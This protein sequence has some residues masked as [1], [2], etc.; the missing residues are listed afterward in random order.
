[1]RDGDS[2]PLPA[3]AGGR[4]EVD[5]HDVIMDEAL[6]FIR[7]NRDRPFFAY[8]GVTIPHAEILVPEDSMAKYRGKFPE[9]NPYVG[10]H[11]ASQPEPRTAYA[12]MIDRLDGDVGRVLDLIVELGLEEDTIVFFTSDNGPITAGGSD[13][14]FFNNAG[15]LRGLKFTFYEGGIRVPLIAR[16]P[17]RVPSGAE[18]DRA[19][20]FQDVLPTATELAGITIPGRVRARLYGFSALPTLLG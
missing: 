17:G 15:P 8:L 7:E 1:M 5:S 6:A 14:E 19:W 4:R 12:G 3:N 18:S 13:P 9:Q 10:D 11:Y 20:C 16:W 2:V